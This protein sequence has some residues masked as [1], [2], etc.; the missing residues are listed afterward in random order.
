MVL[1]NPFY[2]IVSSVRH[3]LYES[4]RAINVTSYESKCLLIIND[5]LE[6]YF[7]ID[8]PMVFKKMLIIL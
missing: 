1:I 2:E 6:E 5:A 7:G 4:H 3:S 8:D